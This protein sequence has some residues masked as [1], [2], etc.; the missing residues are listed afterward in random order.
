MATTKGGL[1]AA[2][3]EQGAAIQQKAGNAVVAGFNAMLSKD[4]YQQ[5]FNELLGERAP[6]F[7]GSLTTMITDDPNMMQ[8]FH[9]APATII[10][11]GLRAAA[12][13]LP[14]DPALGQAYIVP[15]RKKKKDGSYVMEATFIL[16]YKGMYQLAVR[17]GV[18]LKINVVD[19]REGELKKWNRLTEEIEFNFIDDD[20]VRETMPI[21]GY[22][23]YF[24][25]T[26]GMEKTLY[27]T[28]KQIENHEKKFRKGKYMSRGWQDDWESMASK[29]VLRKLLGKWGLLS[30]QY[31][32]Y[33]DSAMLAAAKAIATGQFDDEDALPV[34]I[35]AT[36]VYDDFPKSTHEEAVDMT[37]GEVLQEQP[38]SEDDQILADSLNI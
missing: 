5:R 11:A 33:A 25:L 28:K 34:T 29:T 16:G 26:N 21:I 30:V 24:K 35:E 37:T 13:D 12:Y 6:Q 38:M 4:G 32:N 31:H 27:M 9:D 14:I 2:R 23:A 1:M 22:C 10:K 20:D 19:V 18:Y 3:Q 7:I 15:F 8:V 36:S 17:T